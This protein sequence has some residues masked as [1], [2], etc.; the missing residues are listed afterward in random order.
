[1]RES[2]ERNL[3]IAATISFWR[4]QTPARQIYLEGRQEQSR[5]GQAS[6][7]RCAEVDKL[8]LVAVL[9]I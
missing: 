3:Q 8:D 5:H 1:V 9:Q 4:G 2:V 7:S 6:V